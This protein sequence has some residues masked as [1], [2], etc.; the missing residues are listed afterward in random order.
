MIS[1]LRVFRSCSCRVSGLRHMEFEDASANEEHYHL[2]DDAGCS[3]S[4]AVPFLF[5]RRL[6]SKA[7]TFSLSF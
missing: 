2:R 6:V 5:T 1:I 3:V 4:Y 7:T